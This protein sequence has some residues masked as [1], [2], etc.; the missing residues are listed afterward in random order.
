M[1]NVDTKF[2][3]YEEKLTQQENFIQ[4]REYNN[5]YAEAEKEM[6]EFKNSYPE[7]DDNMIRAVETVTVSMINQGHNPTLEEVYNQMYPEDYR[8]QLKHRAAQNNIIMSDRK[9]SAGS[10]NTQGQIGRASC[11]ER[12]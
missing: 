6:N 10:S 9:T 2:Q 3:T 1:K 8:N 7:L 12:V 4:Q 5:V 11:R